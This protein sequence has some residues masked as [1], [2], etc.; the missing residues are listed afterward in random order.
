MHCRWKCKL[1]QPP[2]KIVLRF[3]KN[4]KTQLPYDPTIPP[5][6]INQTKTTLNQKD[7][8]T[9]MFICSFIYNSQEWKQP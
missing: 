6:G 2:W 4:P 3:L 1:G 9:P 7:I 8:S 5:L